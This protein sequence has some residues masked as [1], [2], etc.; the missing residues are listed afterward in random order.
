MI[1]VNNTPLFSSSSQQI[2]D[3]AKKHNLDLHKVKKFLEPNNVIEREIVF[4]LDSGELKKVMAY[5]SQHNNK[6]GPYKG[7]IRFHPKVN[8]DEVMAL[9]LWMSLKCAVANVP[10]GGGKGGVTIDPKALSETELERLSRAYSRA[11]FDDFGYN[12]DVP[13]PDVNTNPKI[14]EWMV[15]EYVSLA[16][17]SDLKTYAS[18]TGKPVSLHGSMARDFS[19][20]YGGVIV[21]ME[22]LKKL[23]KNPTNL[24]TA[25]QGFGNVG[26]NFALEASKRGLPIISVS[27]SKGAILNTDMTPLDINLVNEC[28]RKQGYLA[29]C[30]CKGGVCDLTLGRQI[31]NEDMLE[32][33]IDIIVPAALESVITRENMERITATIIVEMANGPVSSEAYNF[34]SRKKIIIIPDILANSGGVI[35]SYIEWLENTEEMKLTLDEELSKLNEILSSAFDDVWKISENKKIPLKEAALLAALQKLI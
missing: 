21:L 34:L 30:Y 32:L 18:F 29:G 23:K 27:D 25:V 16:K 19:T 13:A 6:L 35:G 4:K 17:V 24:K 2:I 33:P 14:I 31:K 3:I 1:D 5:R 11:F 8:K 20:G 22:L 10:F 7:G 26:F 15:E 12:K 28:K 9:S